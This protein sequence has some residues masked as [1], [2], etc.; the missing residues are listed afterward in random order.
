[1]A[2]E[3]QRVGFIGLGSMGRPMAANIARAGFDLAVFDVRAEPLQDLGRLGAAVAGSPGEIGAACT[4]ICVMVVDDA[5]VAEVL[6][7]VKRAAGPGGT[8][9]VH[10]TIHPDNA[11]RHAEALARQGIAFVDAPVSG[12]EPAAQAGTLTVMAGGTEA[13]IA[14]CRP[15]L[16]AVGKEIFHVGGVG[17]G[18]TAK[19]VNNMVA[20]INMQA[21]IEGLELARGGGVDLDRMLEVLK[22]SSGRSWATDN[23]KL[24]RQ[25]LAGHTG[26]R[27]ALS[28]IRDKDIRL[29]L[30]VASDAGVRLPTAA[31][32][33]MLEDKA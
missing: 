11:R 19:L 22:V 8:V 14:A 12:A 31:L 10:S 30:A 18:L 23:W 16:E 2:G 28:K 15:V 24:T 4:T 21:A 26:G 9:V 6:D 5:Q 1:M 32:V 3:K 29:A 27:A 7:G 13:A 25:L 17:A 33:S 20:I